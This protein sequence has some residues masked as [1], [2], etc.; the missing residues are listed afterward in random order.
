MTPTIRTI[1]LAALTL[2]LAFTAAGCSD[3]VFGD[4]TQSQCPDGSTITW[5]NFGQ[6]F[7]SDYCTRCHDSKLTGSARQGAPSFH[8][9]D[10]VFGVRAVHDHIDE[11]TASGP[12]STNT[13]MPPDGAKPT[14]ED[15][16]KLGEWIACGSPE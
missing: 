4:P 5:T 13:S 16:Q 10:T 11:T 15:R 2:A 12:A 7:M 9:F 14:L 1:R 6:K 8:D 3:S